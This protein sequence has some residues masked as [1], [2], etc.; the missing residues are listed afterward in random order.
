[1]T[2]F[3]IVENLPA[4]EFTEA[5]VVAVSDLHLGLE[6]SM[7]SKGYYV[8]EFQ[9]EQVKDELRTIAEETESE[10]LVVNGD[11]KNEFST[12]YSEEKEINE[13]LETASNLFEN[14]IVIQGNH[15]LF[16]EETL[17]DHGLRPLESFRK[18]RILFTHGHERPE[19]DWDTIVIGHEHPALALEDEI[20]V[21]EKVPC[22]LHLE[23]EKEVFVLPAFSPISSGTEINR[24]T[25]SELLSPIMKDFDLEQFKA[26]MVSREAGVFEFGRISE[27]NKALNQ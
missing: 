8:P 15:D 3:K 13:L 10:T 24:M 21:T 14:V 12:S 20:G 2:E 22:L 5:G 7:N 26:Y 1:M 17:E 27:I 11:L 6:A 16:I 18:D 9:L 23:G 19:E 4:V 25:S